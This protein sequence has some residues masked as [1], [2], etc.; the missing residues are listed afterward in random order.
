MKVAML[1]LDQEFEFSDAEL[2]KIKEICEALA[3][4]EMAI[5]HLCNEDADLLLAEKVILFTL[6][7]LRD[8][9][10]KTSKALLE[11]FE[12][13]VKERR[14]TEVIHLLKYLRLPDYLDEYDQDQ[15]GCKIRKAKNAALASS[16]LE[17]L[18]PHPSPAQPQEDAV[19]WKLLLVL[20]MARMT[21]K[22][23]K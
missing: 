23:P 19:M 17:R 21:H 14:N 20:K 18:Y 5:G 2:D 8:L 4:I 3:P 1:Q 12:V 9:D 11:T 13:R 6:K 22:Q 15:F 7:K 10:T 16:L